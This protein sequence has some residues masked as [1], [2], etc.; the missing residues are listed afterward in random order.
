ML[1]CY[2]N[3]HQLNK[4]TD[5]HINLTYGRKFDD[6]ENKLISQSGDDPS[7]DLGPF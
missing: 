3:L 7:D 5:Y 2:S 1:P 4:F 6:S